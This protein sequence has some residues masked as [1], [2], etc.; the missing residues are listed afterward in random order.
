MAAFAQNILSRV[1]RACADQLAGVFTG[2]FNLSLSQSVVS[3][4][5]RMPTIGPVPKKVKVAEQNDYRP[6]ELTSVIMKCFERLVK[7][8]ITSTL[9]DIH[10]N[11]HTAHPRLC[12]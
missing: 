3:T 6:I 4:C 7:D 8:H 1:F 11:W 9:P 12:R 5:F 10:N 2:I